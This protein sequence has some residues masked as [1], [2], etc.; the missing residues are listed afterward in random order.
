[1]A[2]GKKKYRCSL[3]I[4][5]DIT[6]GRYDLIVLGGYDYQKF[7]RK[8]VPY[9]FT[10]QNLSSLIEVINNILSIKT[11]AFFIFLPTSTRAWVVPSNLS[12]IKR[13]QALF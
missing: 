10:P 4:P 1:M 11:T 5:E 13:D 8:A 2:L 3:K 12:H 7:L 9:K 6:P